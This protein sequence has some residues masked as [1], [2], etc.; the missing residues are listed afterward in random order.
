MGDLQ[1]DFDI[2]TR[3]KAAENEY[4]EARA[5]HLLRNSVVQEIIITDPVLKAIHSR[6]NATPPERFPPPPALTGFSRP[7]Y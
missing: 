6:A 7:S 2:E 1:L 3:L 4:L 5:A